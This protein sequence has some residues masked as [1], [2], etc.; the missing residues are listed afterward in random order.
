MGVVENTKI[1]V[2]EAAATAASATTNAPAAA[3]ISNVPAVEATPNAQVEST[4]SDALASADTSNVSS[5]TTPPLCRCASYFK[6][7]LMA[8]KKLSCYQHENI[9]PNVIGM[10]ENYLMYV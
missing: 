4:T 2:A 9:P 7:I 5:E 3:S 10:L 6:L 1:S 8:E